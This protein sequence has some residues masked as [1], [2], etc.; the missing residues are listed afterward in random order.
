MLVR[1]MP[2]SVP[3]SFAP[4]SRPPLHRMMRLHARLQEESYPNCRTMAAEL[5]VSPK[6]IQRDIDFMRDQMGMPIE[7][8]ALRNGFHYTQPVTGL[9]TIDVSEGEV[10]AF[11]IAQKAL[12]LYQGTAFEQQ[13]AAAFRKLTDSLREQ[14][15]FSW[16]AMDHAISF[17][18]IGTTI[19]DL[20]AFQEVS[21][22]VLRSQELVFDYRKLRG[23]G[24]ERRRLQPYHLGCV[25][26]QWYAIGFDLEREQMRTFAL[27][28]M[29]KVKMT[30]TR[31]ER[32]AEFTINAHLRQSFGVIPGDGKPFAVR[33]RFDAWAGRLVLE[34]HWHASQRVKELPSGEVELSLELGSI[35]EIKR[36]CLSWG[37]HVKVLAPPELI[38]SVRGTAGTVAKMYRR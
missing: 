4:N 13:L 20:E 17:R 6:T 36:W 21:R 10:V 32:P 15:S 14:I 31:F 22:A 38:E 19:P 9:P 7:Y 8:D 25:K 29:R 33:L 12:A 24:Y 2:R 35:D 5:E 3:Q 26:N 34:R 18:S 16:T 23:A 1:G 28:R 37:A 27:P 11:F 30:A